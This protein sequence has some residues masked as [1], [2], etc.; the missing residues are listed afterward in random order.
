MSEPMSR[1]YTAFIGIDWADKKH[2]I[3]QQ[4]AG[5]N[6]RVFYC[7]HHSV[8]KIDEWAIGLHERFGGP[9]AVAV[10]LSRG[11]IVNALLKYDFL[12]IFPINPTTLA[13]YREA[14]HPS[15][16]KDD[17]TDAE[18]AMDLMLHYPERFK[19][20][21]PQSADMRK[22]AY[23]VEQRRKLVEDKRRFSNR[24][25]DTLKQYYPQPLDW[26]SHRNSPLFCKF[27]IRWP[28]LQKVKRAKESTVIEF[29]RANKATSKKLLNQR[30]KAIKEELPLTDD[31][32]VLLAHQL[33]A[34]AIA[35]QM[36]TAIKVIKTFDI[37]I[38]ESFGKLPDAKLFESLPGAGLCYAPRLLVAFGEQRERFNSAMEVQQYAGVAP[39]TER[40][41]NKEWI[42]W[43]WKCSKFL[44]QTFVEW[45]GKTIDKSYWAG[46]YYQQQRAKGKTYQVAV[47]ALA[48]KWI[49]ILYRCWKTNTPYN[50]VTYLNSL[51]RRG[52]PLMNELGEH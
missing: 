39:V 37:E 50:E 23:L 52:S 43:R 34:V 19:P 17:P 38:E 46:V 41:G 16:A 13:K 4:P 45:A 48:F 7:V 9:I 51:K 30:L 28:S 35:E 25:I 1:S 47:R 31:P 26:F 24:L 22:L 6:D 8:E 3:C 12:S 2:D 36:L 11:P 40:S 15:G 49:R 44:R 5:S 27:I 33:Q 14:F 29:F 42:H 18:I 20:L 32:G 21:K 10:E